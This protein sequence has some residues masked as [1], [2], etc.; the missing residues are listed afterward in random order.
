MS[1]MDDMQSNVPSPDA[2]RAMMGTLMSN[3]ELLKSIS[4]MLGR[5]GEDK[6]PDASTSNET[7]D[8]SEAHQRKET[9]EAS[10]P[11][12]QNIPP[13]LL[14][15]LPKLL[16]AFGSGNDK[17][18]SC[19][20]REALLCALKPYLSQHKAE[21]LERIIQLSRLGDVFEKL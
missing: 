17:S 20:N 13:E 4:G 19:R 2:I 12:M 9:E 14:T 5:S 16:S 11:T 15:K 7:E 3:P 8:K 6:T 18:K 1:E 21:A 10:I